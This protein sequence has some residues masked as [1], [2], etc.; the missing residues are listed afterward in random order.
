[1][2]NEKYNVWKIGSR[3]SGPGTK[4]SSI[5][6]LFCNVGAIFIGRNR[7]TENENN[8]DQLENFH[9]QVKKG[10]IFAI[11]D[12]VKIIAVAIATS[13]PDY[14]QNLGIDTKLLEN[15]GKIIMENGKERLIFDYSFELSDGKSHPSNLMG[16]KADIYKLDEKDI[17]DYTQGIFMRTH[18]EYREKILNL[19]GAYS[20]T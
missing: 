17:F 1:M 6:E 12:G 3:W 20:K 2:E 10:D 18:G 14:V 19:Y 7:D 11:G 8:F 9:K 15:F 4:G 13:S 16:C 5:L